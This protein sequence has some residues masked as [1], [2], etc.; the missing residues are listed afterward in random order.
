MVAKKKTT[1]RRLRSSSRR[2]KGKSA[3]KA[4]TA[5]NRAGWRGLLQFGLVSLPVQAFNAHLPDKEGVAFHQLHATCHSRIHYQKVCPL[6][7]EVSNDE[8]VSGYEYAK[9]KYAV[10]DPAELDR[11]RPARDR[12][13]NIDVF[14]SPEQIDPIYF[15]GR[16]YFLAP[17]GAEAAQPYA[18]LLRAMQRRQRW[19]FGQVVFGGRQVLVVV[20]PDQNALQMAMLHHAAAIKQ[21]SSVV[22]NLPAARSNDKAARL[23]EELIDNWTDEH[24]DLGRYHDRYDEEVH[25]LI[26]AKIDGRAVAAPEEPEEEPAVY[27]LMDAL[28]KSMEHHRAN[29]RHAGNGARPHGRSTSQSGRR[30]RRAS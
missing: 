15:D 20:R 29:G 10:I 1:S 7:G 8:I 23:A 26:A 11:L 14:V 21:P 30:G 18:V 16:M 6:H 2:S 9:G 24:F 5:K 28:R 22:R 3:D 17:D 19:G 25:K 27:N 4:P 12:A 13:L